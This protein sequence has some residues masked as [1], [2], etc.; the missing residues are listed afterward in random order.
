M[1]GISA[2]TIIILATLLLIATPCFAS[3]SDQV[4]PPAGEKTQDTG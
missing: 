2:V 3:A 4:P 1:K